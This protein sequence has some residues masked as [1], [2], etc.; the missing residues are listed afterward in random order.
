[1]TINFNQNRTMK[2]LY[3]I[4]F[5]SVFAIMGIVF[6]VNSL[7]TIKTYNEKDKIYTETDSVVVDYDYNAE[8]SKAIIVEYT[9][10]GQSYRQQSYSYSS[11]PA[12]QGSRVKIK[13]NP[14]N[15]EDIIWASDSKTIMF[16]IVGA[17][18]TVVGIVIIISGIRSGK[19]G[20]GGQNQGMPQTKIVYSNSNVTNEM[21]NNQNFNQQTSQFQQMPQD[22]NQQ[23]FVNQNNNIQNYSN[24]Q[25][26]I[27]NQNNNKNNINSNW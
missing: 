24:Q 25:D 10:D 2:P 20:E 15:P 11:S 3:G 21:P 8:G 1:M 6:L 19:N 4:L 9:V 17:A 23:S 5:G 13:Y 27:N 12:P 14:N 7:S 16:P 18:F 26:Q 22:N